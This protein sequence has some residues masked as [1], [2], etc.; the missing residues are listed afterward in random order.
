[1]SENNLPL[2]VACLPAWNAESF[3][4]HTLKC[5]ANQT[6]KNLKIIISD[7][8]SKDNTVTICENFAAKDGRFRVIRQ[9][10]Q[11]GWT[12]NVNFLL[13]ES[14]KDQPTYLLFAFH[15]D[16]LDPTYVSIL[17]DKLENNPD[18]VLAFS[19]MET[20]Y[21]NGDR[22]VNIYRELD[23]VKQ[24]I[25]RAK[26][27]IEQR[28]DWWTPHRGVFRATAA[29]KIGGLKKHFAGEF[30]ADWPWLLHLSL[31]GE[32]ERVPQILCHKYYKSKSLSRTWT[33]NIRAWLGVAWSCSREVRHSNLSL[34]TEIPLQ[35]LLFKKSLKWLGK[36]IEG[37][38]KL[39][40]T[41]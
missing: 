6:Y 41:K 20:M 3:I 25:E 37:R 32:F 29:Q 12:G 30:A 23:G 28:G 39:L 1:M 13:R 21:T 5:L 27:M 19:D 14:E 40:I 7:D 11:L 26:I 35:F 17:V 38:V 4:E 2:V 16:L 36:G 22:E 33:Y 31:L 8:A 34:Q 10:Q 18:A 15:D 9:N 24:P